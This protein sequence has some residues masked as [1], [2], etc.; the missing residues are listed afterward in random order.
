M[1]RH[2]SATVSLSNFSG[3]FNPA[4]CSSPPGSP[5]VDH[6][7]QGILHVQNPILE[8]SE[9]RILMKGRCRRS[10]LVEHLEG[11]VLVVVQG[12]CGCG[13]RWNRHGLGLCSGGS[14][15]RK[16]LRSWH[17]PRRGNL[18]EAAVAPV[19]W[20]VRASRP[21]VPQIGSGGGD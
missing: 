20:C 11:Q 10:P 17:I 18:E 16:S 4:G 9:L 2:D 5:S 6:T 21:S 19:C 1:A 14:A 8:G 12:L 7:A 15:S 13:S 3:S